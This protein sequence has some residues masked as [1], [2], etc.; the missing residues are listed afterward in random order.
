[1]PVTW[2]LRQYD[3]EFFHK[4]LDSFVPQKIFDAHAHLYRK[5]HWGRPTTMDAGPD[6]V[7]LEEFRSQMEWITPGRQTNGL[8]FGVGFH[9]GFNDS[10]E[11][12]G[13][14]IAKDR[15]CYGHLLVSPKMD[16]EQMRE[17]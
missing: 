8:F 5:S 14:Q 9:D 1:M 17:E 3:R 15:A 11:F 6:P 16:P 4:E 13:E 2:E 7:T 10:N 12:V